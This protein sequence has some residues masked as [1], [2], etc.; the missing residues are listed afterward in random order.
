MES[1]A[2]LG[3]GNRNPN[4]TL[5]LYWRRAPDGAMEIVYVGEHLPTV[6]QVAAGTGDPFLALEARIR[7]RPMSLLQMYPNAFERQADG[8][9]R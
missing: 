8:C 5:H 7:T 9:S 3:H 6:S 4:E 2:L 1:P